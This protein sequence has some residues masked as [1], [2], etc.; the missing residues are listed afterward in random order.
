MTTLNS[1]DKRI[2]QLKKDLAK[3]PRL[4]DITVVCLPAKD[5]YPGTGPQIDRQ[6]DRQT[7]GNVVFYRPGANE[8]E[9]RRL[10][11]EHKRTKTQA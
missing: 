8:E 4:G 3:V 6:T 9:I 5:P 1:I 10:I 7:H 2:E 11:S